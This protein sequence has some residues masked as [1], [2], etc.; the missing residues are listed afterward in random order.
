MRWPVTWY[1]YAGALFL[2]WVVA[3]A[4][5]WVVWRVRQ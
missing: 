2:A 3:E 1:E 4:I 5:A